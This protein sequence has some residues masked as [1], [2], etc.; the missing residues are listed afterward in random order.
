MAHGFDRSELS[1]LAG[2]AAVEDKLG[3]IYRKVSELEDD[4]K[5][6]RAAYIG[7]DSL[8][9]AR[10]FAIGTLGYVGALAAVGAI[11]ASGGTAAAAIL[12]A[13]AVGGTGSAVGS[14]LARSLGR[15]RAKDIE[16]Q[17]DKGGLL[18]WV[19]TKDAEHEARAVDVLKRHEADDVHVH[20]LPASAEPD[21]DP[22]AGL[23]PDPFLPRARV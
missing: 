18:L 14:Y 23:Q 21:A 4:P 12:G 8:N 11:V 15:Q 17:I 19:R 1:L 2:E 22:L 6:P 3:H 10:T 16:T 9:E 13:V 20:D 7:K 5:V